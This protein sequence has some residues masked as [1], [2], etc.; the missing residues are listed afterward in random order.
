[1]AMSFAVAGLKVA[2]VQIQDEGC[3]AKSFPDFWERF[4]WLA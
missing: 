4:S 2:G 3:V 1:M